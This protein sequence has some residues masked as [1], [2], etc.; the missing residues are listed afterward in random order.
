MGKVELAWRD[1]AEVEGPAD[2]RDE[3]GYA[4]LRSYAVIGDGRTVAL[5]ARDGRIDWLP[6][7]NLDS[8]APVRGP[9]RCG[10]GRLPESGPG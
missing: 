8:P 5:V 10:G 3:N 2:D 6:L 4:D 9:G 1:G 7:P